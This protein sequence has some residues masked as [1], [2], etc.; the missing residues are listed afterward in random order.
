MSKGDLTRE[1][2]LD[3]AAEQASVRGLSGVSL[4]DVAG[5]VG[6]SKSGVFKHFQAKDG[7]QQ[8]LLERVMERFT[9]K[10]W[11]PAEPLPPGAAR[12]NVIVDRWL[13]WVDGESRGGCSLTAFAIELDDQPGPLRDFLK[14]QQLR[15]H[16]ALAREFAATREPPLSREEA[17]QRAYEFKALMLGY[18][19]SRRLLDDEQARTMMLAAFRALLERPAAA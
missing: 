10:V 6:L 9:E 19:H 7:L 13:D 5:G 3:E 4:G 18:S 8:A 12:L 17:W 14:A 11:K 15:W 16:K 1:R 2:I